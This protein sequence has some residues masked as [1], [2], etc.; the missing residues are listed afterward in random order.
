M[1]WSDSRRLLHGANKDHHKND[2][3]RYDWERKDTYHSLYER[4]QRDIHNFYKWVQKD[5]H[6]LTL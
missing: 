2:N 4:A 5:V 6:Q 3:L 1:L